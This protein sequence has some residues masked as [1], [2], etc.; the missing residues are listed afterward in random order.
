[1]ANEETLAV[2]SGAVSILC[3]ALSNE[4][5]SLAAWNVARGPSVD[6]Q[7]QHEHGRVAN[8]QTG[9]NFGRD[10]AAPTWEEALSRTGGSLLARKKKKNTTF[11]SRNSRAVCPDAGVAWIGGRRELGPAAWN[12]IVTRPES[13]ICR[14]AASSPPIS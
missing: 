7:P 4:R 6:K 8:K 9:R 14:T 13:R 5:A 2:W 11:L 1:M 10:P 3:E 12:R